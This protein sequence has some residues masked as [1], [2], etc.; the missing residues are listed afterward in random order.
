MISKLIRTKDSDLLK[1]FPDY[2]R[3]ELRAMKKNIPL[4][5]L[6]IL[7][8]DIETVQMKVK[9][10]QLRGNEYIE[11]SRIIDDWYI[12]C[13]SA[14]WLGGKLLNDK[15]TPKEVKTGNDERI[16]KSLWELLN[17]ADYVVAHNGD[18]FDMKKSKT[19]FLKYG[20][21]IPDYHKTIDTLKVVKK[22]FKISSNKL[23]YVCK[24]I[25][26]KGKIQTGGVDLWDKCEAGDAKALDKMSRYCD[27]DVRILEKL[28]LKLINY[29]KL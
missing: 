10:W 6:K 15:L 13:W 18:S 24:F 14:K 25:G 2:T 29:I 20:L 4:K 16:V 19:R 3:N 17:Q 23:D 28:F 5:K 22:H 21:P 9:V 26:L 8:F 1:V 12:V 11:P 27:N 7:S